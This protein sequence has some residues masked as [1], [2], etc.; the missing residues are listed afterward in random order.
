MSAVFTG[1]VALEFESLSSTN[2]YAHLL[3]ARETVFEGTLVRA[4]FQTGGK[5]YGGNIWESERGQ[6]L[7]VSI[8]LKPVFLLPKR[9]FFLNQAISLAVAETIAEVTYLEDIKI[10]W[11]ND[12]FYQDK[13]VAGI[14]IENAVQGNQLLH[15]VAGI[16][17][18]VNQEK[19][20]PELKHVTSLRLMAGGTMDIRKVQDVLCEK[21]EFR[22][23]QL[24]SNHV[25]LLQK[26]YMKQLYRAEE[27]SVF[28]ANGNRFNAKIAG[29]TAEGKLVLQLGDRHEVFGFK[30][31]EMVI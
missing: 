30:E 15:S 13:K 6:N 1:K 24:K 28:R 18:N 3:L 26:D 21:I 31:V 19:F 7:L 14:L 17:L 22:Y 10:K 5:G 29:L 2:E 25:D 9:Q 23:L 11:P 16:G 8:V 20:S 4:S 27:E 12:I